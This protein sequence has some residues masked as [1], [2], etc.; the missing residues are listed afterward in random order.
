MYKIEN[1]R[2]YEITKIKIKEFNDG[3]A[4]INDN[5]EIHPV[6]KTLLTTS[7]EIAIEEMQQQLAE[8]ES[9]TVKN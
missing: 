5:S 1:D 3:I 2:E 9:R 7:L 4:N 6:K 8:Y